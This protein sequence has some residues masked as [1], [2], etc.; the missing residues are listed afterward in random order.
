MS[1]KNKQIDRQRNINIIISINKFY[2]IF[3]FINLFDSAGLA[4]GGNYVLCLQ[5]GDLRQYRQTVIVK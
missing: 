3:V 5:A 2:I 1:L 4:A